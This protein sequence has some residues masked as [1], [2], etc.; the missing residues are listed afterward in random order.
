M[1]L[2]LTFCPFPTTKH[3]G[4]KRFDFDADSNTWFCLKEGETSTLDQLLQD[5]LSL[6]FGTEVQVL[7]E[8]E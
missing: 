3:S 5:E 1:A 6:V 4:P 2:P 8:D 7:L